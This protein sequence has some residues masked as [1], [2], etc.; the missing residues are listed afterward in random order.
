MV[1][2]LGA[3]EASSSVMSFARM[4][5]HRQLMLSQKPARVSWEP[6]NCRP[7]I[8]DSGDAQ[9]VGAIYQLVRERDCDPVDARNGTPFVQRCN[10]RIYAGDRGYRFHTGVSNL[11]RM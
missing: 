10:G 6:H 9:A 2:K 8:A 5:F 1:S 11:G 4:E 7:T 3:L